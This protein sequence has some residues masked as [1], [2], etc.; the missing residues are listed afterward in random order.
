MEW[1]PMAF[2]R[3]EM[4]VRFGIEGDMCQD[5]LVSPDKLL[6]RLL[7]LLFEVLTGMTQVSLFCKPCGLAQMNSEM[8]SRAAQE[9]LSKPIGYP[10]QTQRMV[11][12]PP[13]QQPQ[14]LQTTPQQAAPQQPQVQ[15]KAHLQQGV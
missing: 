5:I 6:N 2:K 13:N 3:E 4:R 15:E 14:L 8:K 1:L 10:P 12:Q 11:Y 9:Q 7:A